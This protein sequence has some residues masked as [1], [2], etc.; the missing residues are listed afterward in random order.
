MRRTKTGSSRAAK[1]SFESPQSPPAFLG[2]IPL[3]S[4]LTSKPLASL[5]RSLSRSWARKAASSVLEGEDEATEDEE[6]VEVDELLRPRDWRMNEGRRALVAG[7]EEE[8]EGADI[9]G[10]ARG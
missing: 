4:R 2:C 7:G 1:T 5:C 9:A 8:D 10:R 6:E 3:T